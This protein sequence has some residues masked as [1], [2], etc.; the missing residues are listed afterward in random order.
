MSV[1]Y[2]QPTNELLFN[3]YSNLLSYIILTGKNSALNNIFVQKTFK[4]S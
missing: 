1:K 3:F 2:N 4:Y